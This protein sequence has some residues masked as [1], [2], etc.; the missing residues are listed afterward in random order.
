MTLRTL[1]LPDTLPADGHQWDEAYNG[2]ARDIAGTM[3]KT[4]RCCTQVEVFV[5]VTRPA[6]DQSE[7][8]TF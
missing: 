7:Y 8:S 6:K 1:S 2:F 3:D 5:P 4:G